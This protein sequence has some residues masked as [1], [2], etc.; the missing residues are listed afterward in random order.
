M[1]P[2]YKLD[3]MVALG[4]IAQAWPAKPPAVLDLAAVQITITPKK[5]PFLSTSAGL[6]AEYMDER[7][8]IYVKEAGIY[9]NFADG[10]LYLPDTDIYLNL[11]YSTDGATFTGGR[12]WIRVPILNTLQ[13]VGRFLPDKA[14]IVT[15]D[16]VRLL[17]NIAVG[18]VNT[19]KFATG[20]IN[21]DLAAT[22]TGL[23]A[24]CAGLRF[25]VIMTV[26]HSYDMLVVAP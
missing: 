3:Q 20:A 13:P 6:L 1:Y 18:G 12:M 23:P 14:H 4:V 24:G 9:C 17:G 8:Q 21:P 22:V 16:H 11:G 2:N 7:D 10:L 26:A 15:G 19:G 25:D 5:M